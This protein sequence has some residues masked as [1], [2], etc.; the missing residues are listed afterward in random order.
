MLSADDAGEMREAVT[1]LIQ[2]MTARNGVG[3]DQIVSIIL[4]GTPDIH[5]AFPAAAARDLGLTDV[6]LLCAQELDIDGAVQ[7]A[8]RIL[9]HVD[10]PTARADIQHVYLRGAEILRQDLTS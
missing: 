4:T 6:P 7:L 5:S 2:E 8:V 10:V 1:E 9:M 3:H